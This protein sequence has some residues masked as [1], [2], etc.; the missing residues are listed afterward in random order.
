MTAA[1]VIGRLLAAGAEQVAVTGLQAL[2]WVAGPL[3]AAWLLWLPLRWRL[4]RRRDRA[5]LRPLPPAA[6]CP[7]CTGRPMEFPDCTC[8]EPCGELWCQAEDPG[9]VGDD[10]IDLFEREWRQQKGEGRG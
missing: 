1:A 4:R 10:V 2:A 7:S 5:P 9:E 6:P 3:L 8:S